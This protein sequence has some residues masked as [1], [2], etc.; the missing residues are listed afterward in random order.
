MMK[1]FK[2][3]ALLASMFILMPAFTSCGDDDDDDPKNLDVSKITGTYSGQLGWKVMTSEGDFDGTYEIQI[4]PEKNDD[5]DVTVVLPECSFTMPGTTMERTIPSLTVRD[6]DVKETGNVYTI[7]EDDFDITVD[8]TKYIG[9]IS[10]TVA[11]RDVKLNYSLQPGQMKMDI[12]FTY[13][14]TLK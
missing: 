5:D 11:G 6:V 7:S 13:T 1:I 9:S 12:N 14:G 2:T 4:L 8:G 10:G 3:M